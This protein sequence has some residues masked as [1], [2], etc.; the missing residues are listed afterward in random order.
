[1]EETTRKWVTGC[2]IGCLVLALIAVL[3]VVGGYLGVKKMIRKAEQTHETML[4]VTET[5]GRISDFSPAP[6]G[7]VDPSRLEAF[8]TARAL[9]ADE[10]MRLE[11]TLSRLSAA[12]ENG[13]EST[14]DAARSVRAGIA[15]IP[16][17]MAYVNRR[18]ESFLE[19]GL[20]LGEY[21]YLY[22][23]IDSS[24]LGHPIDDGPPFVLMG[25]EVRADDW[26][27]PDVR[28]HRAGEIRRRLNRM[29]LPIIRNQL[30][31]V[32]QL[33]PVPHARW[34][35]SLRTE[36]LLLE[37]DPLRLPW[38]DGVPEQTAS[39]FQ[40]FWERLDAEYSALVHPVEFMVTQD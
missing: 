38:Q 6:D 11:T 39:S 17:M 5:F 12:E 1:M 8:L 25:G 16:Q 4:S 27:S 35:E 22:T 18:N 20:G 23:M 9:S 2:G 19:A 29:L 26:S 13:P 7:T 15:I 32:T 30:D 24:W 21:L 31:D 33:A 37:S 10:R 14:M 3:V 36:I 28:E 40:P 34:A